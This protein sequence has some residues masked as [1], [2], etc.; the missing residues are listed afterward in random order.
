[1]NR[2]GWLSIPDPYAAMV[3]AQAGFDSVTLDMQ[4]GLFD[5]AAIIRTLM[6]LPGATPRRLVRVP[7]NEPAMIGKVLDA[8]ADGV[9]APLINS[10]ADARAL[11][12]S[13]WYPQRGQRSFGPSVAALRAGA[14]P[15]TQAAARIEVYA[16]IETREGLEAVDAIAGIDGITGLYVGPNDLAL[17]LGFGAGSDR[18][19]PELHAA[20]RRITG[21]AQR[22]GKTAGLFCAS[23]AYAKQAVA[24]GFDMLTIASDTAALAAGA[25]AALAQFGL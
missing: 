12:A 18:A 21:A 7:A 13:C 25:A 10:A 6:A 3:F 20:F 23:A 22:A 24:F 19:E 14:T 5:Q 15:Y 4:H 17:S 9:I 2:N 8:G 1:V 11:A 16:M